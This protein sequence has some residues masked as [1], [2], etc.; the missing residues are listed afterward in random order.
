MSILSS[1]RP[2]LVAASLA[3]LLALGCGGDSKPV[4][5]TG[6]LVLPDKVK[7]AETDSINIV[8]APEGEAKGTG[9]S[10]TVNPKDLTFSGEVPPGKYKVGVTI[11][12]YAGMKDT[13]ART[14]QLQQ[15][16]GAFN[17]GATP[18]RYEV[19]SD[20]GQ[21]FTVDL[22]KPAISKP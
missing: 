4:R 2:R 5:V 11:T 17:T 16:I 19:T 1:A 22:S 6:K 14:K 10:A 3:L 20:S 15:Q 9:G 12:P 18:L 8:F 13:E 21:S 7:V